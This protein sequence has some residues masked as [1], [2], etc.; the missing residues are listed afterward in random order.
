MKTYQVRSGDSEWI[1]L[2]AKS[3][4]QAC[5]RWIT[6]TMDP[7]AFTQTLFVERPGHGA[8]PYRFSQLAEQWVRKVAPTQNAHSEA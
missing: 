8:K 1:T 7:D 6:E 4:R 2:R 5:D 3:E